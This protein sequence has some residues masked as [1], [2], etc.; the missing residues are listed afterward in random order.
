[1]PEDQIILFAYDDIA[2]SRSNPFPGKVYNKPDPTGP[3]VDVYAGCNIDYKGKDVNP[4]VF[5]N[6]LTGQGDGKVLKSTSADNVFITFFDHGA[7]GLIAF[8]SKELHKTELQNTLQTMADQNMFKRLVFYLEACESGSMFQGMDIPG[9]YALSASNPTESS[10]GTYCSGDAR[11]NGKN[12]GSCLGDLFSVN[13]MEDSDAQDT[14]QEDLDAQFQSVH[15]LT[16][17]SEV[18][19]WG[20][21]SFTAD[22]VSEYVGGYSP[23]A[24]KMSRLPAASGAVSARQVDLERLYFLYS[25]AATSAERLTAGEELQ[26]ELARQ[27]AVDTVYSR[28]LDILYPNDQ[29][30]QEAMRQQKTEAGI[31]ECE[32]AAHEAFRVHGEARFNANSGFAL[33]FHQLVVNVCAD[34][35]GSNVDVA[36][37]ARAACEVLV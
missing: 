21:V 10:W 26:A 19:Q 7:P 29:A 3:G 27:L 12:I 32:M 24:V 5:K 6:V 18:M 14:T 34:V 11:V 37:A 8:P 1:V 25:T 9:V 33:Q 31:M 35:A 15:S 16:T 28:F 17:K 2:N 36:A 13:W 4:T 30:K 23:A 22:K 20:D